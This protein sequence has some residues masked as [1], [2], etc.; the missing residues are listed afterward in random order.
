MFNKKNNYEIMTPEEA[1]EFLHKSVSWVYKYWQE[2]GGRKLGGSLFLP[3]KEDLHELLFSKGKGVEIRLHSERNPAHKCLVQD[4]S[5]SQTG[6][7]KKKGGDTASETISTDPNR[8][9][10]FGTGE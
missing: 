3:G 6:R 10:L 4:K 9:G 7:S 8:H 2:L 1:A 5:G